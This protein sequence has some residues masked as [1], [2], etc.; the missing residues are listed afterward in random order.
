MNENW[1][2]LEPAQRE[3][4]QEALLAAQAAQR[5]TDVLTS[6]TTAQALIESGWGVH[7]IGNANNYFGI[8]AQP[9]DGWTGPVVSVHTKEWSAARG[10]YT[11]TATFRAYP[12]M[13]A[14][15]TDHARY[16]KSN[17]RYSICYGGDYIQFA[18][19]LQEAGYATDPHYSEML[20]HTI[21][22][23][24]LNFYDL[25]PGQ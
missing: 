1:N 18:K 3:F 13:V 10:Y 9:G 25:A 20:I 12:D 23:Y 8:K 6:V 7:R 21:V 5:G 2:L 15:F 19:G 11:I 4:L 22:K 14:S 17:P 16:L 24:G